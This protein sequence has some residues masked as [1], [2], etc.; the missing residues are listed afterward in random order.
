MAWIW[1]YNP[2]ISLDFTGQI[3]HQA[4]NKLDDLGE[5][6]RDDIEV[7][8]GHSD[9]AP[10]CQLRTRT[11]CITRALGG[12]ERIKVMISTHLPMLI[13]SWMSTGALTS[14]MTPRLV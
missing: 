9:V 1:T 10:I 3:L 2:L 6:L 13:K 14:V 8:I 7:D 11:P 5:E 12:T 4:L